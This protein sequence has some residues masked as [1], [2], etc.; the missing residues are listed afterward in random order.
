MEAPWWWGP[1][2]LAGSSW[3][4]P[5]NLGRDLSGLSSC[6]SLSGPSLQYPRSPPHPPA[7]VHGIQLVLK[8]LWDLY[9]WVASGYVAVPFPGGQK[10]LLARVVFLS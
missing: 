5:L 2:R 9:L 10:L 1:A 4:D 6:F 3:W 8:E 7:T